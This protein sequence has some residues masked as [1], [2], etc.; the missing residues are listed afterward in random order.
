MN[1]EKNHPPETLKKNDDELDDTGFD[2]ALPPMAEDEEAGDDGGDLEEFIEDQRDDGMSWLDDRV[3]IDDYDDATIADELGAVSSDKEP[4]WMDDSEADEGLEGA[5]ADIEYGEEYGWTVDSHVVDDGEGWDDEMDLDED[6]G[7]SILDDAGE[8]GVDDDHHEIDMDGWVPLVQDAEGEGVEGDDEAFDLEFEHSF[9]QEMRLSGGLLP[10]ALD[11][12]LL[13]AAWIGPEDADIVAVDYRGTNLYAVGHGLFSPVDRK[14]VPTAASS[15]VFEADANSIAI[16]PEDHDTLVIGTMLAGALISHD[17]G[18]SL[19]PINGWTSLLSDRGSAKTPSCPVSVDMG[20]STPGKPSKIWLLTGYGEAL[21]SCNT[22]AGWEQVLPEHK[23]TA[24]S[25]DPNSPAVALLAKDGE[26]LTLF[27]SADGEHF[28]P[29]PL[30]AE[31]A[32]IASSPE[33]RIALRGASVIAVAEELE[34]GACFSAGSSDGW[35]ALSE[36]PR[37]TTAAFVPTEAS[38]SYLIALYF[39][40]RDLGVLLRGGAEGTDWRVLSDISRLEGL[41]DVD[42]L[43][44][45]EVSTR[46][47]DISINPDV[48]SQLAL[49]TGSGVFVL[50]VKD[51][52]TDDGTQ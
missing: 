28:E 5:E 6:E 36:C 17:G 39:A 10:P 3:G 44:V 12:S 29:R 45:A 11:D 7:P 24:L 50:E 14:L 33:P 26:Q 52:L 34:V 30:P 15:L 43:G 49:A 1:D 48:P 38:G 32:P 18:Q 35:I 47:H 51:M 46:I 25:C 27:W 42:Q 23:I 22:G 19:K 4:T 16:D 20:P 41:F 37:G 2:E 40:G 13:K 9:E 8:E 21:V 31:A